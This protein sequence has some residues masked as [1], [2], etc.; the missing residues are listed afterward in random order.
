MHELHLNYS[1]Q[2]AT[3]KKAR[4]WHKG[5]HISLT[6]DIS[7]WTADII[8]WWICIFHSSIFSCNFLLFICV[9]ELFLHLV[10]T[11]MTENHLLL[12]LPRLFSTLGHIH[13]LLAWQ[14]FNYQNQSGTQRNKADAHVNFPANHEMTFTSV[15]CNLGN[16]ILSIVL[17][18]RNR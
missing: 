2:N 17:N 9:N 14:K 1:V 11:F 5:Y 10:F 7:L 16:L 13:L 15:S 18:L 4:L 8:I 6:S 12:L 3:S